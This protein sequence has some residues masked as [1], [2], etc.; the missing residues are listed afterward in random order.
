MES[1]VKTLSVRV[2]DKHV[3]ELCRQARAVN[4]CWNYCNELSYRSIRERGKFLSGYDF[5]PY[6]K[7]SYKELNLHS[8]T[9]KCV[10]EQYARSRNM[11]KKIRLKW[12]KSI[13]SK[14][15]LGWVPVKGPTIKWKN[16]KVYFYGQYFDVW[17]SYGL[18]NY[19]FRA[20][21]FS[22]DANGKWYLNIAVNI[23]PKKSSGTK[24]IGID[25]GLKDGATLST[26][27]SL[28]PTTW[29]RNAEPKLKVAQRAR[30]KKRVKAIHAKIKNRRKDALHK[31]S[32]QVVKESNA[33]FVG[34]VS[35]KTM[36]K[37]NNAKSVYD[38]SWGILKTML[39][40]KCDHA[41]VVFKVI[42]EA[43]TTQTC[44]ACKNR[45]GPKGLEG[46]GIREWTCSSCGVNHD[47]DVNAAKNILAL[48]H[49]RLAGGIP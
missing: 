36:L 32:T 10:A 14:R 30:K 43:F 4:F 33:I 8:A 49:E 20:G 13:G 6:M 17:D 28:G 35:S 37:K 48:G 39:E 16:G 29:Y 42:N 18:S 26:G 11:R 5:Q 15:S 31:F 24:S 41:G 45:T 23:V 47:R 27:K 12:R 2:K 1:K 25:L 19:A 34:N 44:S 46:L 7:G 40:Y 3:K 38:A 21:S 22:E 9:I